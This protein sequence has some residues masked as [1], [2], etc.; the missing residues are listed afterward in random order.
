MARGG[1]QTPDRSGWPETDLVLTGSAAIL[2]ARLY[3]LPPRTR[4]LGAQPCWLPLRQPPPAQRQ[5]AITMAVAPAVARAG[6]LAGSGGVRL[7]PGQRGIGGLDHRAQEHPLDVL[8]P[9]ESAALSP[10]R[11]QR[12]H[13]DARWQIE[14]LQ[15]AAR[16]QSP[17]AILHPL[18]FALLLALRAGFHPGPAEQDRRGTA[19]GCAFAPGVVAEGTSWAPRLLAHGAI[20]RVR[21]DPDPAHGAVRASSRLGHYQERQLLGAAGGSGL[22]LLVLSLQ[23]A[24]A[25]Q[26]ELR[27]PAMADQSSAPAFIPAGAAGDADVRGLLALPARVGKTKPAS[28][29]TSAV[30]SNRWPPAVSASLPITW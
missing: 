3:G 13:G 9:A 5:R 15:W 29:P 6:R 30:P 21:N 1:Q 17:H 25:A 19:A 28:A 10:F 8:L 20:F 27:L 12:R 22:V 24:I 14:D 7:A 11:E 26:S 16:I 23:G 4:P 18:T 2:S